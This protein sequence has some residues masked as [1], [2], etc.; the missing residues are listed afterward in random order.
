MRWVAL[1]ALIIAL[2]LALWL[3]AELRARHL[4]DS[5]CRQAEI[6]LREVELT[7]MGLGVQLRSAGRALN[8][9]RRKVE[10]LELERAT[11]TCD[12]LPPLDATDESDQLRTYRYL[13]AVLAARQPDGT[14]R[15]S[16]AEIAALTPETVLGERRD[17]DGLVIQVRLGGAP[18]PAA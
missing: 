6:A 17:V 8:N 9:F 5:R 7:K 13:L 10:A 11:H 2:A 14:L 15:I 1:I 4:V 12:R 18:V 16:D 3:R